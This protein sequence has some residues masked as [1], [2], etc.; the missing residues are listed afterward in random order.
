MEYLEF[1]FSGFFTFIGCMMV[2]G[3]IAHILV[4]FFRIFY[5]GEGD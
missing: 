5:T 2:L 4:A 1:M 3:L